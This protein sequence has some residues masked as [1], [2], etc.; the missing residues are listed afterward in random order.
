M[1]WDFKIFVAFLSD[2]IPICGRRRMPYLVAAILAQVFEKIALATLEPTY[3]WLLIDAIWGGSA[4][5]FIGVMLD[6][7]AV[8]NTRLEAAQASFAK[9]SQ[10]SFHMCGGLVMGKDT[11]NPP[12]GV[13]GAP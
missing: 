7:L 6:T 4:Q 8:Q 12:F 2:W 9:I 13:V 3:S 5:V 11:A 1:T 10:L